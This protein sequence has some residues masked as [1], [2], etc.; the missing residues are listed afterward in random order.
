ME[1]L[2]ALRDHEPDPFTSEPAEVEIYVIAV[3]DLIEQMAGPGFESIS[4]IQARFLNEAAMRQVRFAHARL[5]RDRHVALDILGRLFRLGR[6]PRPDGRYEGE[7]LGLSTGLLSDPFFEW[8]TR[9]YLPWLGKTFDAATSTGDNVFVDNAWSRAT[10]KLG[11]P[12]YRVHSDDPPGT[13][14]VFPFRSYVAKGIED[15]DLDVLRI[16]Y[17][18]SPNPLPVRRVVDEVV[19]LPGGYILGKAHMRGLREFRRVCFFGLVNP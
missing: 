16:D 7:L 12:E 1:R 6:A 8:L 13:V 19:E 17:G 3:R 2:N 18:H 15:P 4:D 9:I 10:E 14:R 5:E 11:W